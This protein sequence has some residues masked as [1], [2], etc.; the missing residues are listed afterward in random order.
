MRFRFVRDHAGRFSVEKMCRVLS[1]SRGGYYA[2]L[3]RPESS[4]ARA[5]R[6]LL[7]HIKAVFEVNKKVYGSPRVYHELRGQGIGCGRNRVVRLMRANG[8]RA[9]QSRK[10]RPVTTQSAHSLPVAP[11]VLGRN[12]AVSRADQAWVAD[13]T[14]IPTREGWLYLAVVLDVFNRGVIGWAMRKDL[15]RQIVIRALAMALGRRKPVAGLIHHSDRGSQYASGEYRDL[16]A[17]R[18]IVCSMSRKGDCY[19]NAVV[20]SFFHT[21]KTEQVHHCDYVTRREAEADIFE[22]IEV[23]YNHRRRHSALGYLSPA[24]FERMRLV[25]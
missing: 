16:L 13:I 19:D 9:K 6:R 4:R 8:L 15:S 2:W 14:Y 11:N 21:L 3:R 20:E 18:G 10:F 24:E 22:Y 25:H 17:A 5:N 23:F 7:V 1:V 12:L